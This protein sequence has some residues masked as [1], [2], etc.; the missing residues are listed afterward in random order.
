MIGLVHILLLFM[1]SKA[2]RMQEVL[3]VC[4]VVPPSNINR[5]VCI[6]SRS[7][8]I[9]DVPQILD[10]PPT[11]PPHTHQLFMF[12]PGDDQSCCVDY[13]LCNYFTSALGG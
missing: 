2:T 11:P 10:P 12:Y 7:L 13:S 5:Q 4:S 1:Y 9:T 3:Q 8:S 6:C